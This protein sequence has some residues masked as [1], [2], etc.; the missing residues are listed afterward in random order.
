MISAWFAVLL[1]GSY[2]PIGLLDLIFKFGLLKLLILGPETLFVA[3]AGLPLDLDLLALIASALSI[4][5]T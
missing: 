5:E 4:N 2:N 3:S 1:L